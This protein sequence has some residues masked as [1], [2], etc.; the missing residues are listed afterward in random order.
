MLTSALLELQEG[1]Q[2]YLEAVVKRSINW[3]CSQASPNVC[4]ILAVL[5]SFFMQTSHSCFGC[6]EKLSFFLHQ[7]AQMETPPLM[8]VV[9]TAED[10]F[11]AVDQ[12]EQFLNVGAIQGEFALL[13]MTFVLTIFCF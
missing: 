3:I 7:S 10:F 9:Y 4:F 11:F 13:M 5:E 1:V 2:N 12:L 8:F 6:T